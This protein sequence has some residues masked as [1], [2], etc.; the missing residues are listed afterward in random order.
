M[1]DDWK[2]TC[3]AGG[4]NYLDTSG[5][6]RVPVVQLTGATIRPGTYMGGMARGPGAFDMHTTFAKNFPLRGATK[7]QV[8][9]DI[10]NVWNRKNY[11]NPNQSMTSADF[12]RITGAGRPRVFQLGARFTF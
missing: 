9:A 12:G 5:F 6:T 1:I 3:T 8:R 2:D 7:L 11:N 4:C 10:F